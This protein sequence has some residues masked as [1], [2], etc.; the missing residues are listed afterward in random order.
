MKENST[1]AQ[2]MI[3]RI[4]IL[5]FAF[6]IM[7]VTINCYRQNSHP[8]DKFC[9]DQDK[10][11]MRPENFGIGNGKIT[12]GINGN[13]LFHIEGI[14]APPYVSS[15]FSFQA[16]VNG[17]PVEHPR[18]L[19]RPFYIERSA[20]LGK[21][22]LARTN[23]L[24]IPEG[25]TFIFSLLLK[26]QEE[27]NEAVSLE[28]I[29]NGTLDKM[30]SDSCWGFTAPHSSSATYIKE[31]SKNT[32]ALVQGDNAIVVSASNNLMWDNV[33]NSFTLN[34]KIVP[35]GQIVIYL[36]F[37]IGATMDA[38]EQCN[39][40]ARNPEAS[41]KRANRIYDKRV[42]D[43][44]QK[45]P[46]FGSD[47]TSLVHFYDR[48]LVSLLLNRWDVPEFKLKPF[49]STGSIRGGCVGDY[50]WNVGEC[51]EI[52]SVFDPSATKAHIRQFLETGVKHGFGF[53]PVNGGMLHPNYFYP[54]NQ[55]KVIG[56]TYNY[57]RNSGDIEFLKEKI[58]SGT[59]I[60]SI[61]SEALFLDDISK[62]IS[63]IDYNIC[64]PQHKGGQSHLELRTPIGM[65]NYTNVMP[66][67]NGRR[68]LN[69]VLASRLSELA[70]K[71]R[72]D[73]L[74]RAEA[75]KVELK[76]QLWDFDK[77]WFAYK[78]P[79][80]KPPITE[81]R[82]TVQIFYL[83][84][85][86]V[87]DEEEES[88]ILSHLNDKEFLSEYGM[89]SLSKQD[90]AYFQPDVD[91]GGPGACT[92]FPLNIAK[93]LYIMGKPKL[94]ENI[95]KRILWWGERMPYWGDSFY[96][97]TMRY[98]EETPLQSTIDAITGAQCIIF[99]M[100]GIRPDFDGSIKINPSLPSFA[101]KI[102]LTGV[103]LCNQIFDVTVDHS[104][105]KVSCQGKTLE[106]EIGKAV[107]LSN[108]KLTTN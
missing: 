43:L 81:L 2:W 104:N 59:I 9:I 42:T 30:M 105:Y 40:V 41:V 107:T 47:N 19:W 22:I 32:V 12:A 34:T 50:L 4:Y 69:Y 77:K 84:G 78:M 85:S 91:N 74:T 48:S 7:S 21:A 29:I 36:T 57:I 1:N 24:L 63:L 72:P 79:D 52:L 45:L 64:D 98:R 97:D 70:G 103:R 37:S 68:Y 49:Y 28:F 61:V 53:C 44:Y 31:F 106:T 101:S 90:P 16:R 6:S 55:E 92:C 75:L 54:I 11:I 35:D 76:K 82:Y 73:L 93:T 94:A 102:S 8:V 10:N 58:G 38:I 87:L 80:A 62:P 13:D 88:G 86:G 60:D 17:Q 83:L 108:G 51:Q 26:N 46:E 99:G 39:K 67:L 27:V 100:F 25:R 56:L 20:G 65:L 89:H 71:P 33:H 14:W 23:T 3:S 95:L 66:D 18:Y 15:D 96:A 5:C